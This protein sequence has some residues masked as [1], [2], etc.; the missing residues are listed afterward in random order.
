M[1]NSA[2]RLMLGVVLL[3]TGGMAS[4]AE[5][6]YLSAAADDIPVYTN[7][8]ATGGSKLIGIFH[9]PKTRLPRIEASIRL[10]ARTHAIE[11]ALLRA[12]IDVESGFNPAARSPKGAMGLMQLMPGTARRFGV[13]DAYDA[14]QNI[15]GGTR[16][17][18]QL[19]ELFDGNLQLALAAYN[20]GEG[21]VFRYGNRIPPFA[22][23]NAYVTKVLARYDAQT[24]LVALKRSTP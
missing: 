22:E 14:G 3:A 24:R 8:P 9:A 21:A 12:V 19:L 7:R 16:Y 6:V 1:V 4:C 13:M 23:T 17:L 2:I 18:K 5:H 11:E 10:S 20:A 15:D